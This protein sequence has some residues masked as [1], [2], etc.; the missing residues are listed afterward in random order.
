MHAVDAAV[1]GLRGGQT[2]DHGRTGQLAEH[3]GHAAVHPGAVAHAGVVVAAARVAHHRQVLQHLTAEIGPLTFVLD[4]DQDVA[5]IRAGEGAV[6]GDG[7]VLQAY[8]L[9]C[10]AT[11]ARLQIGHAHQ[12]GGR[13]EQRDLDRRATTGL[14]A[15]E[16]GLLDPDQRI[17]ARIDVAQ[18]H[19]D[20]TPVTRRAVDGHQAAFGLHQQVVGLHLG[21]LAR[22][23]I[24][25]DVAGDEPTVALTQI[26]RAD[27]QALGRPRRQVLNEHVGLGEHALQ[28]RHVLALLEVK[29]NRLLAA[30]DPHEVR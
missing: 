13:I 23:A 10:L 8:P 18:G 15:H 2:V 25:T 5:A 19:P 1:S 3:F 30:V 12:F 16:Q 9:G 22:V 14:S 11:I 17:Q 28:H 7:R 29:G 20:A 4:R 21:Q 6:G 26:V 27:A 24:A